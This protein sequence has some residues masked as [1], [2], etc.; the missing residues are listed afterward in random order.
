VQG[1][2]ASFRN[3][4]GGRENRVH[5]GDADIVGEGRA[6]LSEPDCRPLLWSCDFASSRLRS[7]VPGRG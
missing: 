6:R 3:E 5:G 2:L 7:P 4:R 1:G